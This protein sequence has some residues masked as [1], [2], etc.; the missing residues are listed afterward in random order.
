MIMLKLI[1]RILLAIAVISYFGVDIF[2]VATN[3]IPSLVILLENIIYGISYLA[4]L[5]LMFVLKNNKILYS[6][7]IFIAAFNAG[8]VSEVIINSTGVVDPLAYSHL[9]LFIGVIL[10]VIISF[11]L[12]KET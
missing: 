1:L 8:R 12:L 7:I 4:L 11:L 6:A 5:L 2:F 9:P 3:F 10:I